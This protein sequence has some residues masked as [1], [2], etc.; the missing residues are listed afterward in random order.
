[1]DSLTIC[2]HI[3][4]PTCTVYNDMF[5]VVN[6]IEEFLESIKANIT[7]AGWDDV[8]G[9]GEVE[10]LSCDCVEKVKD[11]D[12]TRRNAESYRRYEGAKKKSSR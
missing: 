2:Q 11:L 8:N 10:R 6:E 3:A 4:C 7:V 9:P 1:M 5:P 12:E